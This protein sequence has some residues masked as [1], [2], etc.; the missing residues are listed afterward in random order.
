MKIVII[1]VILLFLPKF[2]NAETYYENYGK[3]V[4]KGSRFSGEPFNTQSGKDF[5]VFEIN[6]KLYVEHNNIDLNLELIIKKLSSKRDIFYDIKEANVNFENSTWGFLL[7]H[8]FYYKTEQIE[9]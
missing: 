2:L 6:P 1:F 7:G 8:L 9:L 3:I 5:G 4:L